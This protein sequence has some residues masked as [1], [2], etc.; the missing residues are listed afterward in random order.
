MWW[1]NGGRLLKE[2][3]TLPTKKEFTKYLKENYYLDLNVNNLNIS[4]FFTCVGRRDVD[5]SNLG[6]DNLVVG[7]K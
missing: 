1:R 7:K 5:S 3:P 2:K 4:I 6:L